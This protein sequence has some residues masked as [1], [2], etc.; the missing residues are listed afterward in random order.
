M[1]MEDSEPNP[2]YDTLLSYIMYWCNSD[3]LAELADNIMEE[4]GY[5]EE[6]EEVEEEEEEEKEDE[7][8]DEEEYEVYRRLQE[9]QRN[10]LET[11]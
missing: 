6:E 2:K 10:T 3:Q 5:E 8:K 11:P 1:R 4:E 9:E 7:Y